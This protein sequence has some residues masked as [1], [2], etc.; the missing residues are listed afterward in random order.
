MINLSNC[1]AAFKLVTFSD[2]TIELAFYKI[3]CIKNK[4]AVIYQNPC[5]YKN[6]LFGK[7]SIIKKGIN[8]P[9]LSTI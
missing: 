8:E 5:I 1:C 2:V 9:K 7:K 4:C 6:H 3:V